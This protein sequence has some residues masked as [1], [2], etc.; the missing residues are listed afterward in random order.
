[1]GLTNPEPD[2][3]FQEMIVAIRDSLSD[4][5]SSNDGQDGE[6]EDDEEKE[7]GQLSKDDEPGGVMGTITNTGPQRLERCR[8]KPLKLDEFSQPGWSDA[9]D[10]FC[11]RD[12]KHGP[13]ALWD[14]AVVQQE[15]DDYAATPVS[16]TIGE[17]L[18]RLDIVPGI[19]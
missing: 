14:P 16:K 5:A 2:K 17:L 11:D 6:D 9:D 8:Q 4:L 3:A 15:T 10:H 1:V 18:Q 7:Q 13:S 12:T 19:S